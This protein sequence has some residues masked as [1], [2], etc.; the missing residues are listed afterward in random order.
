MSSVLIVGDTVRTPELRHEVPL[1]IPDS[2]F[3]AE[4]DGRR[5]VVTSSMEAARVD[6]LG[7]DLEVHT[8]EEFGADEIRR[9]GLDV[10]SASTELAIRTV[11]GLSL[12]AATVPRDFPLGIADEV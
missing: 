7:T 4:I 5:I 9:G 10:H 6:G 1:G 2:F 11:R 8:T 12:S 3:Y